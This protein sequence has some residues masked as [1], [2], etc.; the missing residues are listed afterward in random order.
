MELS[1]HTLLIFIVLILIV[2]VVVDG[3]RR[4]R[5]EKNAKASFDLN[6]EFDFPEEITDEAESL[7]ADANTETASFSSFES[8]LNVE[9]KKQEQQTPIQPSIQQASR[10]EPEP[11]VSEFGYSKEDSLDESEPDVDFDR[12]PINEDSDLEASSSTH[13]L[14]EDDTDDDF[15]FLDPSTSEAL[16][17]LSEQLKGANTNAHSYEADEL[18]EQEIE[19]IDDEDFAEGVDLDELEAD[20]ELSIMG[21]EAISAEELAARRARFAA[22]QIEWEAQCESL[23]EEL[24]EVR[25]TLEA[26]DEQESIDDNESVDFDD[27]RYS[28]VQAEQ[29]PLNSEIND[30]E[31]D[32]EIE[33]DEVALSLS[34]PVN[35]ASDDA[36]NL[37]ERPKADVVLSLHILSR[38]EEG[39]AGFELINIFNQC[40]LRFGEMKIF[41]RFEEEDGRG[42]IQFSIA[43]S[44]EPGLFDPKTM[45]SSH[46][47]G[48]TFFMSL[49]GATQPLLAY[50]AMSEMAQFVAKSLEGDLLDETHSAFTAQTCEHQREQIID[51]QRKQTLDKLKHNS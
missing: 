5:Q 42:C 29:E 37:S 23:A 16:K 48:L 3:L 43:Q 9:R 14:V 7:N 31:A 33:M 18:S 44:H 24:S 39:F 51:Y 12:L 47:S 22:E 36:E 2:A 49:P 34:Y 11:L 46:F 35:L 41:H 20:G 38:S 26:D 15:E 1:W 30:S 8:Q 10:E 32:T 13:T 25:Q 4:M 19:Q 6:K 45:A 27:D 17:A 40:D 21:V 50:K 28:E